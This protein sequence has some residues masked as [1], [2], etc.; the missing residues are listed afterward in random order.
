[1]S[2]GMLGQ[3]SVVSPLMVLGS[4]IKHRNLIWQLA[5]REVVSRYRGS[6]AGVMWAFIHPLIMLAVYTMVFNGV[7]GTRPG[8]AGTAP[9][10]FGM[11]LF[12]GLIIYSFLAE[13]FHRAP[14]LILNNSNYVKKVVFPLEVLPWMSLCAAVFHALVSVSVLV[15]LYALIYQRL[16]WTAIFFPVLLIPLAL[17]VVGLSWILSSV[18]VFVR[19]IGQ[20]MGPVTTILLFLSPVFYPAS[21][22]PERYR[23]LLDL[24]PL[25]FLIEQSQ[26]ILILG[27][28]PAWW[29]L[30]VYA[31][32]GY[33]V[34]WIGLM[35][36]QQTRKAFADVL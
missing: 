23:W 14:Y 6:M 16:N 26:N 1:M 32:A 36:F 8:L 11:L 18:G 15:V 17:G 27:I 33:L 2:G 7:F 13:S 20:A 5:K 10:E 21:A 24:N 4:L 19:D 28:S 29:G 31:V 25:T 12:S 35:W 9:V 22:M 34:A 3:E 30:V